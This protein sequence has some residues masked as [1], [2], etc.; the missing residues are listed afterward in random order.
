MTLMPLR[1]RLC[2]RKKTAKHYFEQNDERWIL[3]SDQGAQE[4]ARDCL[5]LQPLLDRFEGWRYVD[6][7]ST[8]DAILRRGHDFW[9]RASETACD[10]A[11]SRGNVFRSYLGRLV[12]V[13]VGGITVVVEDD[14]NAMRMVTAF[15]VMGPF[16]EPGAEPDLERCEWYAVRRATS[17]AS[18]KTDE[19]ES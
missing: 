2:R 8:E 10:Q 19:V 1:D 9:K 12:L 6:D 15:H 3:F 14:Q 4:W 7:G 5:A 11:P 16:S 17:G 13:G 18:D